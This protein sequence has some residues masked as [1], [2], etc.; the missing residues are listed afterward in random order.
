QLCHYHFVRFQFH[1]HYYL[2]NRLQLQFLYNQVR[3]FS[4]ASLLVFLFHRLN[5]FLLHFLYSLFDFHLFFLLFFLFYFLYF[6]SCFLFFVLDFASSSDFVV[7]F[8][9]FSLFVCYVLLVVFSVV[10][11]ILF[12]SS[13][14]PQAVKK[15]AKI[16]LPISK[17]VFFI[18]KPSFY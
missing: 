2:H 1:I 13:L 4:L 18:T 5:L 8:S 7:L 10:L 9:L 16:K 6:L 3:P 15:T 17:T 11:F 14:P 12:E